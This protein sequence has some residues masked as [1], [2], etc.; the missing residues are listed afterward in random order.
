MCHIIEEFWICIE[1]LTKG[2]GLDKQSV[3]PQNHLN[4]KLF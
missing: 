1:I 2:A 3:V 4:V